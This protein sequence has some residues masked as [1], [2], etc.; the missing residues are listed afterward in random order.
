LKEQTHRNKRY[1]Y[2]FAHKIVHKT[3]M[4]YEKKECTQD[5][6]VQTIVIINRSECESADKN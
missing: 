1:V 4:M 5:G 6:G 2:I 3:M